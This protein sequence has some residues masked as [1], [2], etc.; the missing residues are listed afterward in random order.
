[1]SYNPAIPQSTD[2]ISNS[3]PQIL[4][5]FSQLNTI[6]D[7]NH[8]TWNDA[9]AANRGLHRKIDFPTPTTVSAPTGNDSVLYPKTVAAATELVFDNAALSMQITN[10]ALA[11]ASGEGMLPGGLL[12]KCGSG[13]ILNGNSTQAVVFTTAFPTGTLSV[14]CGPDNTNTI[15]QSDLVT[16]AGFNAKRLG[17]SGSASFYWIAIGY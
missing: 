10:S 1:M 4:A 12:I 9:T 11:V 2:L 5:N 8:F 15:I 7:F 14:V 3:Q 6:F 13:S 16:T 17:T